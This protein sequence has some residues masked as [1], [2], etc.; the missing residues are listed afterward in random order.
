MYNQKKKCIVIPCYNVINHIDDVISKIDF[1]IIDK[2][3]I[4]DDCC[5]QNTG[6]YL[7][8]KNKNKK[9]NVTILKRNVGVGGATKIGF[10]KALN[11]GF[12]IIFKIDG[13]GQHNPTDIK[14]FLKVLTKPNF[15]FCKGSRFLKKS[16]KNKI[17]F[18]RY[19][20]NIIL[21]LFTKHNCG[22]IKITDAVNGYLAIKSS[23][24]KKINLDKVSS[25]FFFEEDLLFHLSFHKLLL[26]EIPIKTIYHNYNNSNL[27]PIKTIIPFMINHLKN[28]FLRIYVKKIKY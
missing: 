21:T 13:D 1:K 22:N 17:P 19:Y 4:I 25:N 8:K 3:F 24:L 18:V 26:K 23:L 5:P 15:N 12:D 11:L 7:K 14:K 9:I 2:V 28:F 6:K 10:K 16:D 27:S 20:G